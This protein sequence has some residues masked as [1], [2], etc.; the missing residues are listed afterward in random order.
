MK[1]SFFDGFLSIFSHVAKFWKK[2]EKNNQK[3]TKKL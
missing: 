2:E 1:K 3:I